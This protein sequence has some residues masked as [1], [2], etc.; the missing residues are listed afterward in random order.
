MISTSRDWRQL[1]RESDR[2]QKRGDFQSKPYMGQVTG[3]DA[4][5]DRIQI[6]GPTG[7]PYISL[8]HPF[9]SANSWIRAIPENNSSIWLHARQD[10][11]RL[12]M[13]GYN[14]DI[15]GNRITD[16]QNGLG[17]YRPLQQ[18]EIDFSSY[19]V[20]GMLG[21]RDGTLEL[22]GGLVY[23]E[24]SH[25]RLEIWS[26][27]PLHSR[28]GVLSTDATIGDEER[29]GTVRRFK[30]A[31]DFQAA[32]IVG[33]D[34]PLVQ[35]EYYRDLKVLQQS[36]TAK[37]TGSRGTPAFLMRM[38]EG[39]VVDSV[40]KV[41]TQDITSLPLRGL[42]EYYVNPQ[43]YSSNGKLS[44]QV[45]DSGNFYVVLPQEAT[46]GG[47]L[48]IPAGEFIG[49]IGQNLRLQVSHLTKIDSGDNIEMNSNAETKHTAQQ[50]YSIE[51]LQNLFMTVQQTLSA[52]VQILAEIKAPIVKLGSAGPLSG[53]HTQLTHPVD[54]VTGWSIASSAT[55]SATS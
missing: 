39:N 37:L 51:T 48:K 29:Y 43:Q 4:S 53:V 35:K 17:V 52:T 54:F 16:F 47:Q 1:N 46:A 50:N 23:G 5:N 6:S 13:L 12:G 24:Y 8:S 19:G 9:L 15:L 44:V 42:R 45:D 7:A 27:A 33:S 40:G 18:G 2:Y 21:R 30:N 10:N 31:T 28:K 22:R 36:V 20:A 55:V 3:Y 26:R 14:S 38:Q 49:I 34:N 32:V 41:M 25:P 11:Q